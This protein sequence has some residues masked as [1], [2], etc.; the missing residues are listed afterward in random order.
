MT[1]SFCEYR[2][3]RAQLL[4]YEF[5]T[6]CLKILVE[7]RWIIIVWKHCRRSKYFCWKGPNGMMTYFQFGIKKRILLKTILTKLLT[8][9]TDWWHRASSS[10]YDDSMWFLIPKTKKQPAIQDPNDPQ[11]PLVLLLLSCNWPF[12]SL[13]S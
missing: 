11:G 4:P 12:T 3:N 6:H 1:F 5:Q 13:S 10:V 9:P 8:D 2:I 7:Q